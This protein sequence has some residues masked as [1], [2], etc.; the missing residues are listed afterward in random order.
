MP[1]AADREVHTKHKFVVSSN[2]FKSFIEFQ[3]MSELS[4]DFAQIDYWEGG[5]LI[6]IKV[7][8]RATFADVTLERGTSQFYSFHNW[9]NQVADVSRDFGGRGKPYPRFKTDD[10]AIFQRDL[11]NT[12]LRSWDLIG[13]WPKKYVAGDWDNSADEV[14]IEQLV[15]AYDY[16]TKGE[17]G[18]GHGI[19]ALLGGP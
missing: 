1:F 10:F 16:F 9:A 13:V 19:F 15:L 7:P 4:I 2:K 6:P 17:A 3:K 5:S 12:T 18:G 8:G 14:V 11:D